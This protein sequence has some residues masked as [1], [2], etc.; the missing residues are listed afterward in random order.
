MA[1]VNANEPSAP[2][3]TGRYSGHGERALRYLHHALENL[4]N[5]PES[6]A[7]L[8]SAAVYYHHT[9]LLAHVWFRE[10]GVPYPGG[11]RPH[12]EPDTLDAFYS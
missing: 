9:E 6:F 8:R 4:N 2:G 5:R 12:R 3:R 1:A 10:M 7:S 11:E